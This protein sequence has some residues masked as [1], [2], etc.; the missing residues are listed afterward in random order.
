MRQV[1]KASYLPLELSD[2]FEIWH[3]AQQPSRVLFW[4]LFP[5]LL[6]N[7]GNKHQNN[8][9]DGCWA[10]CTILR[11]YNNSRKKKKDTKFKHPILHPIIKSG[12]NVLLH[13]EMGP[14]M[15]LETDFNHLNTKCN[16]RVW[17]KK[18]RGLCDS[19]W[20]VICKMV[21]I[22][23][24]PQCVTEKYDLQLFCNTTLKLTPIQCSHCLQTNLV[25]FHWL[26]Q[27]QVPWRQGSVWILI[28]LSHFKP[29]WPNATIC[30]HSLKS[31]MVQVIAWCWW[32]QAIT[33]TTVDKSSGRSCGIQMRSIS[34]EMPDMSGILDISL[35]IINLI[36]Q[37]HLVGIRLD[38][39]CLITT[40]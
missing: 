36:S 10:T 23:F 24:W 33:W 18:K 21:V 32:H 4:C 38:C 13:T 28:L 6:S 1:S 34:K 3:V 39:I 20:N 8:P 16:I 15:T 14:W 26:A 19:F 27:S 5:V 17:I 22:L 40:H 25:I 12:D 29:L 2:H 9:I 30:W 37:L 7:M 31:T 11:W 35:K